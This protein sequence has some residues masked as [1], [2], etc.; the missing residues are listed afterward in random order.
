MLSGLTFYGREGNWFNT[1]NFVHSLH[2]P[3]LCFLR[4]REVSLKFEDFEKNLQTEEADENIFRLP[5]LSHPFNLLVHN[6]LLRVLIY[7]D[8]YKT[9]KHCLLVFMTNNSIKPFMK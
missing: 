5:N 1:L 7:V 9:S 3:Q 6:V 8:I 4:F 2:G